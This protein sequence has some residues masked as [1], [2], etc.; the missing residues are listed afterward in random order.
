MGTGPELNSEL[1]TREVLAWH[2][3]HRPQG[4]SIAA[5]LFTAAPDAV[6]GAVHGT[7]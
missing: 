1:V 4:F 3:C 7:S 5:S 6:V 2:F